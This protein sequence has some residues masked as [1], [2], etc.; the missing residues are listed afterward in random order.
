MDVNTRSSR[1]SIGPDQ[2][3]KRDGYTVYFLSLDGAIAT[4]EKEPA[5]DDT[6]RVTVEF[7]DRKS[8]RKLSAA[9]ATNTRSAEFRRAVREMKTELSRHGRPRR[10]LS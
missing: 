2:T 7:R 9:I 8:E 6:C 1:R 5:D 3:G 4:V 10:R